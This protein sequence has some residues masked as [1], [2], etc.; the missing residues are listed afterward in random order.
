MLEWGVGAL[1][2][3]LAIVAIGIIGVVCMIRSFAHNEG[4]SQ[5]ER[6]RSEYLKLLRRYED[7]YDDY[8]C[9]RTLAEHI[10]VDLSEW[11]RRMREIETEVDNIVREERA[12]ADAAPAEL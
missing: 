11:A 2:I 1:I 8:D 7:R 10:C 6:L 5:L 12:A 4:G 3:S 9:G